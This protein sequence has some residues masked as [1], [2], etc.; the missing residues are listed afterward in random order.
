MSEEEFDAEPEPV[1]EE[2]PSLTQTILS[3][4]SEDDDLGTPDATKETDETPDF[5]DIVKPSRGPPGGGRLV[6]EGAP[7]KPAGGPPTRGPPAIESEVPSEEED[8]SSSPTSV[9]RPVLQPV[10]RTILTPVDSNEVDDEVNEVTILKPVNRAV[11]KPVI[12]PSSEEEE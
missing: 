5:A 12:S 10:S 3:A 4:I 8:D 6:R 2:Q 1:V 9:L 11:L 7:E